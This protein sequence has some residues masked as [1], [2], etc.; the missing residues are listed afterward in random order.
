MNK[1]LLLIIVFSFFMTNDNIM[2]VQHGPL[3]NEAV[4]AKLSTSQDNPALSIE[5][6]LDK[7][8]ADLKERKRKEKE[9]NCE[10][11][12]REMA[13]IVALEKWANKHNATK[14]SYKKNSYK[15]NPVSLAQLSI[16]T[17]EGVVDIP[18]DIPT[19]SSDSPTLFGTILRYTM[20]T[21]G[22]GTRKDMNNYSC[23]IKDLIDVLAS[24]IQ[25][26]QCN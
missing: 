20:K 17:D 10:L 13:A 19:Q 25:Q 9:I 21:N 11:L 23:E 18:S 22:W 26:A 12:S 3:P 5:E 16:I 4:K 8:L 24:E 7:K 1:S 14:I 6:L 2:C 15:F